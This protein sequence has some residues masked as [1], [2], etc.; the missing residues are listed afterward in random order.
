MLIFWDLGHDR[1]GVNGKVGFAFF[2]GLNQTM[3][4]MMSVLLVFITERPVFLRE[5]AN[6]TYGV[7][8]YFMS[9]SL[10]EAPF[11]LLFPILISLITYFAVGFTAEIGKFLIFCL[12]LMTVVFTATS[13]GFFLGC[14]FDN[15][16]KATTG[17]MLFM[18]PYFIFGGYFVNL[19][20]VYVWLRWL[21]YLSP[22]RYSMEALLRNEFEDNSDYSADDQKVYEQYDYNI[23]LWGCIGLLFLWAVIFRIVAV[24]ALRVTVAKV[25]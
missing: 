2:L 16:S 9:K 6:K 11:Q 22:I 20:D 25:Q 3:T 5:Y 12:I 15:S 19:K 17:S 14:L 18:M 8:P 7:M 23:G 10:V 21:Q 24:I 13:V 1:T 4:G